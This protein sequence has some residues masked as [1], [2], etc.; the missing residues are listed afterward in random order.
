MVY[1][2][3]FVYLEQFNKGV[4]VATGNCDWFFRE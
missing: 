3:Y 2:L 1:S 4:K